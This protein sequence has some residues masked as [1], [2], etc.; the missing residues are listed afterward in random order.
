M[1]VGARGRTLTTGL[2]YVIVGEN[3]VTKYSSGLVG[4]QTFIKTKHGDVLTLSDILPPP[5]KLRALFIGKTP[6]PNSVKKGHY[7][8]GKEGQ[9]FWKKLTNYGV[10]KVISG[11]YHDDSLLENGFGITDIIKIPHEPRN[12][13][14]EEEYREGAKRVINL[15]EVY[16]PSVT[17]FVYKGGLDKILK[18]HFGKNTKSRYG[19]N[20][21]LEGILHCRVFVF[22]MPGRRDCKRDEIH[23]SMKLLTELLKSTK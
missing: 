13:P 18:H 23:R 7:F 19:L 22:P 8:Q 20:K 1:M 4:H 11:N 14:A 5:A 2:Q 3:E 16:Q 21:K 9:L 17:I 15:I 12:E 6:T 10:L